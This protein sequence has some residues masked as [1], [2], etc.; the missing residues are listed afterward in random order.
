MFTGGGLLAQ[1]PGLHS[2]FQPP[3]ASITALSD[4]CAG[5]PVLNR[6]WPAEEHL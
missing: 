6:E 2:F 5:D 4:L 3:Q 1:A